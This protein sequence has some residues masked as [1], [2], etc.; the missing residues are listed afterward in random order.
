[1]GIKHFWGWFNKNYKMHISSIR[2]NENLPDIDIRIDNLMI[3]MNGIFH[4][5]AQ[6]IYHYGNCKVPKRFLGNKTV[7]YTLT[8]QIKLFEDICNTVSNLLEVVQPKKRLILC[9]DG[10]APLSKQNQQRQRRFRS[11]IE[12][13]T[14]QYFDSNCITPGTSFM[15]YL[16]KYIDWYIRKQLS[17]NPK[18]SDLEVVFSNEKVPGEGEHSCIQYIRKYGN[19]KDTFCIH[20]L[21]AD[22]IMLSL[23]THMPKFYILRDDMYD[24]NNEFFCIDIGDVR[25]DLADDLSWESEKFIFDKKIAINDFILLCFMVGNDFLPHIPSIEIIENGI[26]LIINIYKNVCPY[27][28]HITS[29]K[30]NSVKIVLSSLKMFLEKIGDYEKYNFERKLSSKRSYFPDKLVN[31]ATSQKETKYIFNIEKYKKIYIQTHFKDQNIEKISHEYLEG[32]QWV[33]SYYTKGVPSWE[34]YFKYHYAP[35]ASILALYVDT[36]KFKNYGVTLPSKPF[37]QLLSVLPPKSSNLLPK[38]FSNLLSDNESPLKEFCPTEIVIDLDGKSREW[39]GLVLLPFLDYKLVRNIYYETLTNSQ[40]NLTEKEQI[41]LQKELKRNIKGNVLL[42]KKDLYKK[43]LFKSYYG[44]FE[45]SVKIQ[46]IDL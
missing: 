30:G 34:W 2:K 41:T 23:A 8:H 14:E 4:N 40:K 39:E 38:P 18:W 45:S 15:D 37:Q 24:F 9:V 16:S 29:I 21:D 32:L 6:K 42:Y 36:F 1:M 13:K 20:G 26:E 43:K 44:D 33:L 22:L 25:F 46:I 10:P 5:S 35:P 17:S 11:S 12:R 27:Y 3:D 19:K 7:K 31:L 28:G